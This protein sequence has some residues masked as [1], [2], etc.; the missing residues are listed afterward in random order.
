M[1]FFSVLLLIRSWTESLISS[2]DAVLEF[3]DEK[4]KIVN[5]LLNKDETNTVQIDMSKATI[6]KMN[7][8]FNRINLEKAELALTEEKPAI[9]TIADLMKDIQTSVHNNYKNSFDRYGSSLNNGLD[10]TEFNVSIKGVNLNI[11]K[12]SIKVSIINY[13]NHVFKTSTNYSPVIRDKNKEVL[14]RALA[15]IVSLGNEHEELEAK[16]EGKLL[17]MM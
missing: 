7:L 5:F 10:W 1:L 8:I 11:S 17:M 14:N 12:D 2:I 9:D 15:Y 13:T 6:G 16:L 3:T 4:V